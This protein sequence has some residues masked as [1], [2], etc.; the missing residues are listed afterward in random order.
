MRRLGADAGLSNA[1]LTD[2]GTARYGH[3]VVAIGSSALVYGGADLDGPLDPPQP[4]WFS[5]ELSEPGAFLEVVQNNVATRLPS[6]VGAPGT[7]VSGANTVLLFG[8]NAEGTFLE[9]RTNPGLDVTALDDVPVTAVET[10]ADRPHRFGQ[11]F[12][13]E[14]GSAIVVGGRGLNDPVFPHVG[15]SAPDDLDILVPCSIANACRF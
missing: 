10:V 4:L 9:I 2:L 5:P 8:G 6:R 11:A 14:D 12:V 13:M 7:F 15:A 3:T 1:A